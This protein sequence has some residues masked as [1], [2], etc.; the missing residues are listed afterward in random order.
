LKIHIFYD[1]VDFRVKNWRK[2]KKLVEKVIT[3]E[4]NCSGDLNFIIT[5]DDVLKEINIKFLKHNYYTDVISFNY[6]YNNSLLGEIFISI[7]TVKR[8]AKNYK[9]SYR[10]EFLRVLIHGVLHICSY[11][12][13]TDYERKKMSMRE[14]YWLMI[15]R[16]L[17][18]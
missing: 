14:D 18:E 7:D 2:I 16:K 15:Y 5:T 17:I 6:D 8:N 3:K 10:N 11:D 4:C 9:L 13:K 12:D 1:N